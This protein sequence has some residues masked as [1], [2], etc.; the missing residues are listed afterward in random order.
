[1][2]QSVLSNLGILLLMHLLINTIYHLNQQKKLHFRI[3][4]F[5]HISIVFA[6][7]ISMFYFPVQIEG[8]LFDLRIIPLI[9]LSL[10]HGWK[11]TIPTI[12]LTS[13]WRLF[14]GGEGVTHEVIFG[15][16]L[17]CIIPILAYPSNVD[18]LAYLK[19]FL[20]VSSSWF[21][22]D[23]FIIWTLEDGKEIFNQIAFFRYTS[24][25]LASTIMYFFIH[26]GIKHLEL[27][28][29]LQHFSE[30]DSLT[31]LY[32]MRKFED[33]VNTYQSYNRQS[34]IAMVDIDN[35]KR[36]ND[37][38]GHQVGDKIIKRVAEIC[39]KHCNQDVFISRYGGDEFI[40]F[41]ASENHQKTF[42][43]LDSIRQEIRKSKDL[44]NICENR[45]N[46]SLSIG[47][48]ALPGPVYLKQTIEQADMQLYSSK[49]Q[50][51]NRV[52][53]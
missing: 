28:K 2:V 17:P 9:F 12:L 10:F 11:Y 40:L 43:I 23:F 46:L 24:I 30:R 18:K 29:K 26:T 25:M 39:L 27:L 6:T 38:F 37:S 1:M 50:G 21:I 5:L 14:L 8:H 31:G 42:Q 20:I 45:F 48:S 52:C 13:I 7:V 19:P 34:F 32:N 49:Q 22:S 4:P 53:G 35:F 15:I 36:I 3:V 41:I 16:V 51:R 33:L 47:F 44:A